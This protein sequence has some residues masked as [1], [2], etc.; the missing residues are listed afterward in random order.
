MRGTVHLLPTAH[1]KGAGVFAQLGMHHYLLEHQRITKAERLE[2]EKC[3][4]RAAKQPAANDSSFTPDPV[5][6]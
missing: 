4:V 1:L 6:A 3:M 2:R 5:V